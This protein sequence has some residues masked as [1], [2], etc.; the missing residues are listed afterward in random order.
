VEVPIW[1]SN[2][3]DPEVRVDD[4]SD[5]FP[6]LIPTEP[7]VAGKEPNLVQVEDEGEVRVVGR[8]G[9]TKLGGPFQT[10]TF[11][12]SGPLWL[13][14]PGSY[15]PAIIACSGKL[16]AIRGYTTPHACHGVI[17]GIIWHKAIMKTTKIRDDV[18]SSEQVGLFEGT[19]I[20]STN[21]AGFSHGAF[22]FIVELAGSAPQDG[23]RP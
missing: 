21:A 8:N 5:F 6:L 7:V 11:L 13:G 3:L 10:V 23:A 4:E 19:P 12:E 9:G 2:Y 16:W 14:I 20:S 22:E 17:R 15:T 1:Q 18:E